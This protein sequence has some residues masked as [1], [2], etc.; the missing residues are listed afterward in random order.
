MAF[1]DWSPTAAENT[2]VGAVFIGENC[3]PGNLNN[4]IRE[5]MAQARAAFSRA[6]GSFFA[7]NTLADARTSLKVLGTEGVEPMTAN[8]QRQ[9]AGPHLYHATQAYA[10]G[11]MFVTA[12]GAADPTSQPGDIWIQ[13]S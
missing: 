10:S 8:I 6:L 13:L 7:S 1:S 3:P 12:A 4:G 11:R 9:G 5:V 2:T